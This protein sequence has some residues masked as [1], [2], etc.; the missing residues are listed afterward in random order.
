MADIEQLKAD[1][2]TE[3]SD[4]PEVFIRRQVSEAKSSLEWFTQQHSQYSQAEAPEWFR[5]ILEYLS[6]DF[7]YSEPKTPYTI[8]DVADAF[9]EDQLE[10]LVEH[11]NWWKNDPEGFQEAHPHLDWIG[12]GESGPTEHP[13][14][15]E[16]I[17][18]CYRWIREAT[19]YRLWKF[20]QAVEKRA[21][22]LL[23]EQLTD[24]AFGRAG[25]RGIAKVARN[26][27]DTEAKALRKRLLTDNEAQRKQVLEA[28]ERRKAG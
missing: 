26:T 13:W 18:L 4:F 25:G 12:D 14:G 23:Q 2:Q 16:T 11:V 3:W 6:E 19:P 27:F 15:D 5:H 28:V 21:V 20:K 1:I 10:A 7:S 8:K 22:N 17:A 24:M 9:E